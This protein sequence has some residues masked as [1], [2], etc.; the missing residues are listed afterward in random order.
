MNGLQML[1]SPY[2][3]RLEQANKAS[4]PQELTQI[5]YEKV[6]Q[7][8]IPAMRNESQCATASKPWRDKPS[9]D[10]KKKLEMR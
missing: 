8:S 3:N 5:L 6:K 2:L 4:S 7:R 1:T 9:K 10:E